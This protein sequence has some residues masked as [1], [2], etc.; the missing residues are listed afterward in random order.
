M[1]WKQSARLG[2]LLVNQYD[3][4]DRSEACLMLASG[5]VNYA[6]AES[7]ETAVSAAVTVAD[8]LLAEGY[9]VTLSCSGWPA[10][11]PP[12]VLSGPLGR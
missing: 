12:G 10:G 11:P 9:R 1:H 7:V 8:R 2:K 6:S 3:A 4:A 5:G